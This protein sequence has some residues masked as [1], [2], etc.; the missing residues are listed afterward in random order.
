[1]EVWTLLRAFSRLLLGSWGFY[2]P[3]YECLPKWKPAQRSHTADLSRDDESTHYSQHCLWPSSEA[4]RRRCRVP[5]F[6]KVKP[7]HSLCIS[8]SFIWIQ[9]SIQHQMQVEGSYFVCA[10]VLDVYS[11]SSYVSICC[12]FSIHACLKISRSDARKIPGLTT[13]HQI[14]GRTAP[15][16]GLCVE[17]PCLRTG[18]MKE[19]SRWRFDRSLV[20]RVKAPV[21][22]LNPWAQAVLLCMRDRIDQSMDHIRNTGGHVRINTCS[23]PQPATTRCRRTQR[24]HND[25]PP[26]DYSVFNHSLTGTKSSTL[27]SYCDVCNV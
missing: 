3:L 5:W 4:S 12:C 25:K 13:K 16:R 24:V 2:T 21:R 20:P 7:K 14:L 23:S 22:A 19:C 11:P 8:Q 10:C 6:N 27:M 15:L 17:I 26:T 18:V 9:S 1:M